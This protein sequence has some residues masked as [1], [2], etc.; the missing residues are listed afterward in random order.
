MIIS[1]RNKF[2]KIVSLEALKYIQA[3]MIIGV[4]TGTTIAYF[5]RYLKKIKNIIK[6]AVST[7]YDT[8]YKL[9]DSKIPILEANQVK[10]IDIYIDSADEFNSD[11]MMIKG[12]GGALTKEKII[13]SMSKKKIII[14]E[15][16]KKVDILGNFP[17]PIEVIPIA[18]NYIIKKLKK[19]GGK[20]KYRKNIITDNGNIIIDLHNLKI[21]NPIFLENKI[22]SIP[23]VVTVGLFAKK[24]AD[25]ILFATKKG[26]KKI[27]SKYKIKNNKDKIKI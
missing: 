7:S 5:I 9:I 3:N 15:E 23:G 21:S 10:Y 12:G 27:K 6:G 25:L 11:L 17:L 18:K 8:T 16:S 19:I 20:A 2:K 14:A 4:G 22:N 13:F 1:E 26:I 24:T